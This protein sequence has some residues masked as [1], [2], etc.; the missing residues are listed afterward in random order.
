M[1]FLTP[2]LWN[3]PA[4]DILHWLIGSV[5]ISN[6][7]KWNQHKQVF[8]ENSTLTCYFE[9]EDPTFLDDVGCAGSESRL[10]DCPNP[11][12]AVEDCSHSEDAGVVCLPEEGQWK[13]C[14]IGTFY[15]STNLTFNILRCSDKISYYFQCIPGKLLLSVLKF[16]N[17]CILFVFDSNQFMTKHLN[18]MVL[19]SKIKTRLTTQNPL[20]KWMWLLDVML[21]FALDRLNVTLVICTKKK[22][23]RETLA[24]KY[25]ALIWV[26]SCSM[27]H[28]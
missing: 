12:W 2:V 7:A 25:F 24:E 11:G 13:L 28:C 20:C 27:S 21:A 3:C 19:H 15:D 18:Y 1:Y 5:E 22:T 9:G 17:C 14:G 8:T 4:F 26:I 10:V 6:F 23:Y 16:H